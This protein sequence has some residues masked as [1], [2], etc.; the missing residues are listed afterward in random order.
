METRKYIFF[1]RVSV[2]QK[3]LLY[4][5]PMFYG[6]KILK[7]KNKIKTLANHFH[8]RIRTHTFTPR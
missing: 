2:K 7:N 3:D 8:T 4:N 5:E 1:R 6:D